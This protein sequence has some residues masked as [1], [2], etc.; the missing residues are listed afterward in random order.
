MDSNAENIANIASD[1]WVNTLVDPKFDN[2]EIGLTTILAKNAVKDISDKQL[3]E[4][5]N[6]LKDFILTEIDKL[7][8]PDA[9][10]ILSCDYSPD[11]ILNSFANECLISEL[12]FPW[13]TTMWIGKDFC[14]VKYGYGTS[15]QYLYVTESRLNRCIKSAEDNIR[16]YETKDAEYFEKWSSFSKQEILKDAKTELKLAR[17]NLKNFKSGKPVCEIIVH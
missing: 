9:T 4:F 15:I 12:N 2:G 3:D 14:Q 11:A 6:L 7:D 10:F 17:Q 1:W 5:R 13:K 16:Y 8:Y